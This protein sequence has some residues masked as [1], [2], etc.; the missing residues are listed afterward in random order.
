MARSGEPC[1]PND[2]GA[3]R[4]AQSVSPAARTVIGRTLPLATFT[5]VSRRGGR[6]HDAYARDQGVQGVTHRF[7]MPYQATAALLT[8][9]VYRSGM[10]GLAR[11]GLTTAYLTTPITRRLTG[12]TT[13]ID[14]GLNVMA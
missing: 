2:N 14:G 10:E 1:S 8:Q 5:L 4:F 12:T 13:Y 6:V 7:R 3:L 11:I 9:T